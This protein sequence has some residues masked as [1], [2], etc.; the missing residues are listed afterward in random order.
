MSK[1]KCLFIRK[2]FCAVIILFLQTANLDVCHQ[3]TLRNPLEKITKKNTWMS[4]IKLM[5]FSHNIWILV[6]LTNRAAFQFGNLSEMSSFT[7]MNLWLTH[8]PTANAKNPLGILWSWNCSDLQ[9][10][11]LQT[12]KLVKSKWGKKQG[13]AA[14][15]SDSTRL[16]YRNIRS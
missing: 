9:C 3:K 16:H 2:V 7:K 13:G 14:I 1:L 5:C 15:A 12:K 6:Y 8:L 11:T 4:P 10:D